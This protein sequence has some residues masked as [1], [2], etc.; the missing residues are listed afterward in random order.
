MLKRKDFLHQNIRYSFHYHKTRLERINQLSKDYEKLKKFLLEI[1]KGK[2]PNTLFN[3]KNIPRVSNFKL[4]GIKSAYIR[5]YSKQLI[6]SGKIL[7]FDSNYKL[8][9]YAEE[10]YQN[11]RQHKLRENPGHD[12]ILKNILIRDP[13]SI[14]I[15]VPIWK[16]VNGS[17]ITGH[18]D[19]I[20]IEDDHIKI[21][22][23]KPEGNFLYSLPQVASYGLLFKSIFKYDNVKCISFNKHHAWQ[24]NPDILLYD[25]KEYLLNHKFNTKKWERFVT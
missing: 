14:A 10:V 25:L 21:V 7:K 2:I 5:S 22:D 9:H 3:K 11:F 8:S 4:K 19:L 13:T 20:K 23:Y 15:E 12:P 6:R 18:I 1:Y 24:Y 16:N 17:Y